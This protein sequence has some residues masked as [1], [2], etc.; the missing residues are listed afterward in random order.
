MTLFYDRLPEDTSG[1]RLARIT[2]KEELILC[3]EVHF[4]TGR[5]GVDTVLRRAALSGRVEI[6]GEILHHFADVMNV[7]GDLTIT[8]ALDAKSYSSLKNHWMRC[9]VQP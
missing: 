9:K 6:D 8:V 5:T 7:A 1:L 4:V 2:T 3:E